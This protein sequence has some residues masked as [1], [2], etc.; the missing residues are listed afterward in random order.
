MPD[1]PFHEETGSLLRRGAARALDLVAL[2]PVTR[3]LLS[4]A[5]RWRGGQSF[6][7]LTYHRI[8]GP[9]DP[10]F[11]GVSVRRFERQMACLAATCNVL[12]ASE[13][14]RRA[15]DGTLP[16]AAVAVTFDD[17]YASVHRVAWPIMKR[18]GVT[19]MV[20]VP[21]GPLMS[22][23]PL[24]Y[25]RVT[26]AFKH[27]GVDRLGEVGFPG[28][29]HAHLDTVARRVLAADRALD[30]L[31]AMSEID[32]DRGVE[33]LER[34]LRPI[35]WHYEPSIEH[36]SLEEL[37]HNV[38]E[39]L[40]IGSHSVTHPIFSRIEPLRMRSELRESKGQ[41]EGW[42]QRD[43]DVFA[44]PNGAVGDYSERTI[45]ELEGAGY[46]FAFC[47]QS[48]INRDD[49]RDH[50]YALRR[51]DATETSAPR[52]VLRLAALNLAA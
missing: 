18:Y 48:G 17:S 16:P 30:R 27:A 21:T 3:P 7:V 6:T 9:T 25:D 19:G 22:G 26:H 4:M 40:E 31:R 8:G 28:L 39:G 47:T 42:L 41:L 32:R 52:L 33:L 34:A 29:D 45:G 14:L 36:A 46:R 12:P 23:E 38:G 44:Y 13:L 5:R 50:R 35:P 43:V 11:T 10:F 37:R 51:N 20:F 15:E 49:W 2:T 24:W 1:G